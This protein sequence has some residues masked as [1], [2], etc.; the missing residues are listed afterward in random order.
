MPFSSYSAKG[1]TAT[2]WYEE[3]TDGVALQVTEFEPPHRTPDAPVLVFVAGWI[4]LRMAWDPVLLELAARY[5]VLY[6]ESREKGTA[7]VPRRSK[8]E[9]TL[10]RMADDIRDIV[11]Q[12]VPEGVSF[13]LIGSSLGST[14]ILHHL[15]RQGREPD[16]V[17]V[18]APNIR[19]D[20]PWWLWPFMRVVPAA[21][22]AWLRPILKWNL[23]HL[24]LDQTSEP[25]QI[26][27]YAAYLDAADARRLKKNAW[28]IRHYSLLDRLPHVTTPVTAIGA[29]SD[30]LH[31]LEEIE[32]MVSLLPNADLEVMASNRETHSALAGR[33][34]VDVITKRMQGDAVNSS[35]PGEA[36]V[37]ANQRPEDEP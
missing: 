3:L 1:I 32:Y 8:I 26:R 13:W 6:V 20:L 28:A 24:R 23:K 14:A 19:F 11:D 30:L 17:I 16:G 31:G 7:R 18:V 36:E 21:F 35:V 5:P 29:R 4:S 37:P 33:L 9:F 15:S 2:E 22:F 27:R 25:E 34:M 12:C 10:D